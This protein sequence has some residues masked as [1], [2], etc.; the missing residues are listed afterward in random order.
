[1]KI[2]NLINKLFS[3]KDKSHGVV[4]EGNSVDLILAPIHLTE[5]Q[6]T[7]QVI[8]DWGQIPMTVLTPPRYDE[9]SHEMVERNDRLPIVL[10]DD[11]NTDLSRSFKKGDLVKRKTGSWHGV[12][13]GTYDT[14]LTP[15]GYNVMSLLEF[16]AVHVEPART[17]ESWD[18]NWEMDPRAVE[19]I[20]HAL[21]M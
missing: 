15:E 17:L 8:R 5:D 6:F 14:S 10:P 3:Q 9:E 12:V 4:Q 7:N 13:V 18:G 20:H 16:G 2:V 11:Q 21:R 19:V 1:M